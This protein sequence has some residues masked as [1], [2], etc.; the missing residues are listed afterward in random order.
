MNN[1]CSLTDAPVS[2]LTLR[3]Y[4]RV[5]FRQKYVIAVSIITVL[6][7]V[8][9]GVLFK[10][11]VYTA[12]VTMLLSAEKQVETPH[13]RDLPTRAVEATLTQTEMVTARPVLERVVQSATASSSRTGEAR[14]RWLRRPRRQALRSASTRSS[15]RSGSSR[16]GRIRG[17]DMRPPMPG[18]E[19]MGRA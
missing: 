17:C 9:V 14:S 18:V 12:T 6:A 7:V 13:Y 11:P 15:S 5:L 16:P 8:T 2:D 19:R 4:A 10:T 3:D 1:D